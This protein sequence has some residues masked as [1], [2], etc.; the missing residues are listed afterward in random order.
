MSALVLEDVSKS[1]GGTV[2]VEG[3]NLTFGAGELVTFLGPSGCGK[4]T[5]LRIIAGLET[6]DTGRVLLDGT[7]VTLMPAHKRDMGMVFQSL[8]LF[9]HLD[10]GDN[11]AFGP[12]LQGASRAACEARAAALLDMLQLPGFARRP[13]QQLSGGQRQ[14]VAIARALAL[15][16]RLFLLDEPMSALDANLRDAMQIELRRLQQRLGI[17]TIVVT[18]DQTE[19]MTMSDKI[20]VF[21]K[22]RVQQVGTPLDIYKHPAN[23]FVAEFIGA[24]NLLPAVRTADGKV[25]VQGQQFGV[26]SMPRGLGDGAA[27]VLM[28]RPE[29]VIVTPGAAPQGSNALVGT[30][31]FVRDIG[32]VIELL[33]DAGGQEILAVMTPKDC[34]E[35]ALGDCVTA[36]LPAAACLVLAA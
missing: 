5:L 7:D 34:P 16:P 35:V 2:A 21:G 4:T 30:V 8:A 17:T 13:V 22:S 1:Y 3:V 33:I 11:I 14:R 31:S 25:S 32:H 36:S 20:A 27:I 24:S 19:A 15:Q 12:R 28:A 29:D 18:H 23:R 10:V 6:P 26:A 9:P